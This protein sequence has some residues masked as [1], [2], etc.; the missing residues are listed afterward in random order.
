MPLTP[1]QWKRHLER[2]ENG[3]KKCYECGRLGRRSWREG[4]F[5]LNDCRECGAT[6]RE[7]VPLVSLDAREQLRDVAANAA[8]IDLPNGASTP[9]GNVSN[10]V[11][12]RH[13]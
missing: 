2:E 5:V 10:A 6:D 7:F 8:R 1:E 13:A 12:L 11:D 9:A 3:I 4:D